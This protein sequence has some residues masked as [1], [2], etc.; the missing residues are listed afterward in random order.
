MARH[1]SGFL[2]QPDDGMQF[3][4]YIHL[5]S[6]ISFRYIPSLVASLGCTEE[7]WEKISSFAKENDREL[8]LQKMDL[9][10]ER[11]VIIPEMLV[12]EFPFICPFESTE[13]RGEVVFFSRHEA[14]RTLE[15]IQADFL[16]EDELEYIYQVGR[17]NS[18]FPFNPL[19]ARDT[20]R[21]MDYSISDCTVKSPAGFGGL[22]FGEWTKT[23]WD[24]TKGQF[25][26]KGGGANFWPWQHEEWV[27]CLSDY[28][29]SSSE[30]PEAKAALRAVFRLV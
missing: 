2:E 12:M 15:E 13:S 29:Y 28:R 19:S 3:R 24:E 1:F 10:I 9:S 30:M 17:Q 4:K 21:W 6:G 7:G 26:I 8:Y 18:L 5:D 25:V 14:Q 16:T 23:P 22:Y 20:A 11:K 27:W